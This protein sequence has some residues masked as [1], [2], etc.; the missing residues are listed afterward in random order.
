VNFIGTYAGVAAVLCIYS[1]VSRSVRMM[2]AV[3]AA[4]IASYCVLGYF[5]PLT[6]GDWLQFVCGACALIFLL[7]RGKRL[8][9][10][11]KGVLIAPV[12]A[13]A[14]YFAIQQASTLMHKDFGKMLADRVT[15]LLPTARET[16]TETKAWDSRV[17]SIG[18]EL[19]IWMANPLMGQ[20]FAS[21]NALVARG[22]L[23]NTSAYGHNGWSSV[24]ATTGIFG[25]AGFMSV[26]GSLLV[27]GRRLVFNG[28]N[29]GQIML[30]A[31]A[32]TCGVFAFINVLTSGVW[33]Q[34]LAVF[35]GVMC[36]AALRMRDIQLSADL[37]P[38][39]DDLHVYEEMEDSSHPVAGAL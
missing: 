7:P 3:P 9:S 15:S 28:H 5:A 22:E 35:I 31:A 37:E 36:G 34:R 39:D 10:F 14:F 21:Q 2:P 4:V 12:L 38:H 19:Q 8:R 18:Q 20:G 13:V 16:S 33:F 17:G 32:F 6:R 23:E 24:L 25:F 1:I 29:R 27:V 30:G 11:F 26:V